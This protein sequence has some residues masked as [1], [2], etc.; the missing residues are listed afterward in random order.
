MIRLHVDQDLSAAAR[1]VVDGAQCHYLRNVMRCCA[2]DEIALFNGRDGE[3]QARIATIERKACE[4]AVAARLRSQIAV[5]DIWLLFA[6]VKSARL[7]FIAQKASQKTKPF[8]TAEKPQPKPKPQ[9][10]SA[11]KTSIP[12]SALIENSSF[13]GLDI[14]THSVKYAQVKKAF[15]GLQGINFGSFPVPDTLTDMDDRQKNRLLSE[16]LQKNLQNRRFKNALFTSAVYGL[17]VL[18]K[19]IKVQ[20]TAQN[21]FAKPN[22]SDN[23]E[24]TCVTGFGIAL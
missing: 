17:K 2:G 13:V 21:E 3:W 22:E 20:K 19:N 7:D 10:Q 14:G 4:L 15:G 12:L 1:V 16:T 18:F 11:L 5:P 8:R 24:E 9:K 23:M 6:P